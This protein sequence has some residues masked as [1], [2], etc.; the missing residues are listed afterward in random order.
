MKKV[1]A[2]R[3]QINPWSYAHKVNVYIKAKEKI[4]RK[5]E[6]DRNDDDLL[7]EGVDYEEKYSLSKKGEG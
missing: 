5:A 2:K 4:I 7:D 3:D 6:R 1:V